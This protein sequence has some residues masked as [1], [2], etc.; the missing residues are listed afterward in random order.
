[1]PFVGLGT[2]CPDKGHAPSDAALNH[3]ENGLTL[4][5]FNADL[6]HL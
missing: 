5:E 4:D 3:L 2:S 6:G 1:M